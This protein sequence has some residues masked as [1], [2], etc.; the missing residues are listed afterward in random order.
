MEVYNLNA[1]LEGYDILIILEVYNLNAILEGYFREPFYN[2]YLFF[3][4]ISE[5]ILDEV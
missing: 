1:L 2:D 5:A 3:K 4:I